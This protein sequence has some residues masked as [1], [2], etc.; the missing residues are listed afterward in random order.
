MLHHLVL[1]SLLCISLPLYAADQAISNAIL[2]NI[3]TMYLYTG[4]EQTQQMINEVRT[5]AAEFYRDVLKARNLQ[6]VPSTKETIALIAQARYHLPIAQLLIGRS[7]QQKLKGFEQAE[8]W[9]NDQPFNAYDQL[10]CTAIYQHFVK[11]ISA[12]ERLKTEKEIIEC[13]RA[14]A[15]DHNKEITAIKACTKPEDFDKLPIF[16]KTDFTA[17]LEKYKVFDK[18]KEVVISRKII[19][20]TQFMK[21]LNHVYPKTERLDMC[22]TCQLAKKTKKCGGCMEVYFCSTDCQKKA[23]PEHKKSC[24]KKHK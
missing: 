9:L 20:E 4:T 8:K 21:A 13:K 1:F 2:H 24:Q 10:N 7:I 12:S 19:L 3:K 23:W 5:S 22:H 16:I 14:A 11:D 6:D 18:A 15:D 17:A